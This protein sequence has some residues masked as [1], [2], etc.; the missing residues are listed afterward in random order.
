VK[1]LS[2]IVPC[3]NVGQ[4]IDRCVESLTSQTLDK[5][6]YEI[7]LV[8]DASTD[9]TW[10]HIEDWE[11]RFP[12]IIITV[13]CDVNGKMGRARNIGLTYASGEYIG[14]ADSDDW[15]EPEM[16]EKM[17]EAAENGKMDVVVCKSIRDHGNDYDKSKAGTGRI[18]VMNIDS[19]VKRKEFIVAN[20]MSYA[21]WD[22]IIR[23]SLLSDNNI[24][25]PEGFAYEDIY[26]GTLLHLY[27]DKEND[28]FEGNA[29]LKKEFSRIMKAYQPQLE[30]NGLT[31]SDEGSLEVNK[32]VIQ[33]AASDGTLSD[34]F[35]AL[36]SFKKSIQR[37]AD[38]ISIN[39]MNYVNNKIV[40]Y[41]NPYKPVND[42][43]NL[44]AYSGMMF[45]GYI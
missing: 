40:A 27:A 15:T 7:I 29:K 39:P 4:Y 16:F 6:Q 18:D 33:K 41:K 42:P 23:H 13:H 37:K 20:P 19:E 9:D 26:Y 34:V 44:S 10:K 12:K 3:Y 17:L 30:R 8:D 5:S 25:F 21:V 1:K 36:D 22:K 45:N 32:V 14:Y 35:N 24:S 11:N 2:V 28:K 43:Y 31:V 38:D